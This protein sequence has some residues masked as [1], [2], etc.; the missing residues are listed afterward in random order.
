MDDYLYYLYL[1]LEA[2]GRSK[3]GADCRFKPLSGLEE[4]VRARGR[5]RNELYVVGGC[6]S[7]PRD[8]CLGK[9]FVEEVSDVEGGQ[10]VREC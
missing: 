3:E 6:E 2:S 8:E 5:D 9:Y 7:D 4:S 1:L 10:L